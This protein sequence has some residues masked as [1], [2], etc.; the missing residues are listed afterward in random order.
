MPSITPFG[1]ASE[2]QLGCQSDPL[3]IAC[4]APARHFV[5]RRL[6]EP[7]QRMDRPSVCLDG[8]RRKQRT[9][10]L[11]HEGHEF[12]GKSGHRAA[13]ANSADVGAA[14]NSAHPAALAHIALHHRTPASQFHDAERGAVFLG[15][16][17]LLVIASAIAAFVDRVAEQPGRP[18][19]L[20]ERNHRRAARAM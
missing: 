10:R 1:S 9:G 20:V 15:K 19:R 16:L 13:D 2:S 6:R 7:A 17:G 12:V 3:G 11:I 14:A 4:R 5:Q 18:Q 8:G